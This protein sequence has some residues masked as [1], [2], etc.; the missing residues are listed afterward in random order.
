MFISLEHWLAHLSACLFDSLVSC[1]LPYALLPSVNLEFIFVGLFNIGWVGNKPW[2]NLLL[3]LCS[4]RAEYLPGCRPV[5]AHLAEGASCWLQWKL[6][7]VPEYL[8]S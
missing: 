2:L 4:V 6:Q 5:S 1:L 3:T 8:I 7:K